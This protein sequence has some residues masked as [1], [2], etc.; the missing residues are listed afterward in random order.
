MFLYVYKHLQITH[1]SNTQ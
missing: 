1:H